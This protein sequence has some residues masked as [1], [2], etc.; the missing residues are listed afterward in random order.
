[1]K[2]L[3]IDGE[4]SRRDDRTSVEEAIQMGDHGNGRVNHKERSNGILYM[5]LYS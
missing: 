2:L 5:S 3:L 4:R 1:M